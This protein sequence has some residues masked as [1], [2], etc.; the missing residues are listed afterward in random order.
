M[1]PAYDPPSA[2]FED[3]QLEPPP[4]YEDQ[5]PDSVF[6]SPRAE[7]TASA[8]DTTSL[9][10]ISAKDIFGAGVT[11]LSKI[12]GIVGDAVKSK[13]SDDTDTPVKTLPKI[14][15]FEDVPVRVPTNRQARELTALEKVQ[16][17]L[18]ASADD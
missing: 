12:L 14:P 17:A 18:A 9:G 4:F 6:D 7:D 8:G 1:E 2:A 11:I 3:I 15:E 16:Q 13:R 10:D 5:S